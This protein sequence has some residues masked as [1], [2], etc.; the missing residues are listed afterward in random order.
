MVV[1]KWETICPDMVPS[2]PGAEG[3]RLEPCRLFTTVSDMFPKKAVAS[4]IGLGGMFGGLGGILLNKLGGWLFDAYRGGGIAKTWTEARNGD[5]GAYLNQ[6]LE[7]KL[8]N[9]HDMPINLNMVELGGLP[10][11]VAAQLQ[12]ISPDAFDKLKQ[13]QTTI[14]Q[15][16]MRTAYVIMF[17]ICALAYL[18]AWVVMKVL[19]PR[20]KKIENL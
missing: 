9:S 3:Y 2:A 14:V 4:A 10:H 16:E 5:L 12:K 8:R 20:Y 13:L 17:A 6:I 19:V 1:A 15:G 7:L 11:D 18:A